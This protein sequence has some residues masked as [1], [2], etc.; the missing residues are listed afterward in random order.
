MKQYLDLVRYILENGE[1]K[2]DRTNTGTLSIFGYQ[3]KINLQEGFPLLTTKK[4]IFHSVVR[5]LLWFVKGATN[6]NNG[7][8][9]SKIWDPWADEKGELG[10]IYGY[11][12]RK[13]EKFSDKDGSFQ[14]EHIDQLKNV[15]E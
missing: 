7:L 11:Q 9:P 8:K 6:I 13:W 5:E 4:V 1:E 3:M 2:K 15:I 10:P 12:W 14:K